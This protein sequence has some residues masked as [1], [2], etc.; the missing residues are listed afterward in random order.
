MLT[1]QDV[2]AIVDVQAFGY[3]LAELV[4]PLRVEDISRFF[5]MLAVHYETRL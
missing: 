2:A 3:I 1:L 5:Y 4:Y